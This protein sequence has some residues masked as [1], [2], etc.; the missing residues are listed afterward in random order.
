MKIPVEHWTKW[1]KR[2]AKRLRK[3]H[4]PVYASGKRLENIRNSIKK[5]VEKLKTKNL[6]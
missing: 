3:K 1:E 4:K 6:I 2:E 5:R